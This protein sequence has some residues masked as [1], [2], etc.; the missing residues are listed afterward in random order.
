MFS[1]K[2]TATFEV[3]LSI[4]VKTVASGIASHLTVV[5]TGKFSTNSGALVSSIINFAEVL[6]VFPQI[7]FAVKTTFT[8]P[9][10][11]HE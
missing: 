2:I 9:I 7:S 6:I 10:K 11:S 3:Q 5:F 4:A 8:S 1:V